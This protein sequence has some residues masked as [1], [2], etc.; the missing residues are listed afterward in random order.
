M[1]SEPT[2]AE[3]RAVCQ[4]AHVQARAAAEHWVAHAYLRKLSP[5][6]TRRLVAAGASADSVTWMMIGIGARP[7][8]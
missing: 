5:Y 1:R 8:P 4:P 7:P 2:I 6:L 3:M